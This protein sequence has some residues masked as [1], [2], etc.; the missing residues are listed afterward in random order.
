MLPKD[1]IVF[2]E[3]PQGRDAR[4]AHAAALAQAWGAHLIATFVVDRLELDPHAGF[5]TGSGLADMLKHHDL[6]VGEA[7]QQARQAFERELQRRQISGE[8]RVSE[9]EVGEALML[10]A[11]HASL[12]VIGPSRPDPRRATT[13]GLSR[14]LIFASGRPTLLLPIDWPVERSARRI[15]VGWNASREATRAIADAMP[16]LVGANE[17]H[18]VVVP[19]AN[20]GAYGHEP[21][22]D[23]ARH[24]VRYGVPVVLEQC[25]GVDAGAVLLERCSA[26]GADLLVMGAVGRSRISEFVFGGATHSV[27]E[28]AALPLLLSR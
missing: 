4:L 9:G 10:H 22:A 1:L 2:I 14:D 16:F 21:G 28:R 18:L 23:M 17:V 8:W 25:E 24:L 6:E 27:L 11:R 13:L 12:A 5:A 3:E 7:M 26:L 15:V 19:E 20:G